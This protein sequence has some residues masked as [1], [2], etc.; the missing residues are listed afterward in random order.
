M[1][2]MIGKVTKNMAHTKQKYGAHLSFS[3]QSE[4]VNKNT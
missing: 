4:D 1:G 2:A 3:L